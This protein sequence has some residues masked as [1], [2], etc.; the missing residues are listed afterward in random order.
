[1]FDAHF[2]YQFC[3]IGRCRTSQGTYLSSGYHNNLAHIMKY[4]DD[5]KTD[6]V[7]SSL[8]RFL[9]ALSEMHGSND[10]SNRHCTITFIGDS[11]M[12]D[13][14]VA[15]E[16]QLMSIGYKNST[17]CVF[18]HIGKE[19]Y[20]KNTNYVCHN[21]TIN[22]QNKQTLHFQRQ[23]VNLLSE[24][25]PIINL[26]FIS[27]IFLFEISTDEFIKN[28]MHRSEDHSKRKKLLLVNYGA[29][30]NDKEHLTSIY[31]KMVKTLQVLINQ[32]DYKVLWKEIEPQNFQS[33]NGY[34]NTNLKNLTCLNTLQK[35]DNWK[36]TILEDLIASK[37]F[38]SLPI[39][40]IYNDTLPFSFLHQEPD[41][42][43]YCYLP[44]RFTLLWNKL[45]DLL[46]INGTMNK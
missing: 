26:S 32:S 10:K 34:F 33:S 14:M 19:D 45:A 25:C 15:M 39:V 20:Y 6:V 31:L 35:H 46:F 12:S 7:R 38:P 11:L 8:K 5:N 17:E 30:S 18:D 29:H 37:N 2:I 40:Y 13:T 24:S 4:N 16:C 21:S 36:T 41:C 44:Y 9:Y 42:T 1:M 43:H 23:F 28:F 3:I 27:N 22:N